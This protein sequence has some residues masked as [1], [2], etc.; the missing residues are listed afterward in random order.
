[1]S[2]AISR[3]I[4]VLYATDARDYPSERHFTPD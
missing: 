2:P 4:L 1:V 3:S